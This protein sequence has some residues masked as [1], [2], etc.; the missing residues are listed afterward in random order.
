MAL[1]K[2]IQ[3]S[4]V[5]LKILQGRVQHYENPEFPDVKA[6]LRKAEEAEIKLPAFTGS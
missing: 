5:M 4:K 6:G 1:R 2:L 3:V